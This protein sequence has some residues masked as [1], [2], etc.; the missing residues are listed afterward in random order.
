M[1]LLY[2]TV[3]KFI[4]EASLLQVAV[5]MKLFLIGK[6]LQRNMDTV[7]SGIINRLSCRFVPRQMPTEACFPRL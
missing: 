6:A 4:S 5:I 2:Y 1:P 3:H 7:F